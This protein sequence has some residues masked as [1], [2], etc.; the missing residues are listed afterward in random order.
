MQAVV[1]DIVWAG[2]ETG[3]IL[4]IHNNNN[5]HNHN[6]EAE[7]HLGNAKGLPADSG[8]IVSERCNVCIEGFTEKTG[9]TAEMNGGGGNTLT[10]TRAA[11]SK[12]CCI[13]NYHYFSQ[14]HCNIDGFCR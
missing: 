7:E 3:Y 10:V 9:T 13:Y 5:N 11:A 8:T 14:C 1:R 6:H 4:T 12:E 2:K